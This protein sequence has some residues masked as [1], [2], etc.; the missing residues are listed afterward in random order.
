MLT[1]FTEEQRFT[2]WWLWL[3]LIL[4]SLIPIYAIYQQLIRGIPAGDKPISDVG[5]ILVAVFVFGLIALFRWMR[6]YTR[7]D[8]R[9]IFFH[10]RPF[11]QKRIS[12][13]E[14]RSAQ[15]VDYGFV[16]YGIRY[17]SRHG[18]V[19][20]T[21]GSKGLALVL[22]NGKKLVIGTQRP[23]ELRRFLQAHGLERTL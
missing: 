15:V 8:Q 5:V 17:G 6:L 4:I 20:N 18:V 21:N 11:V 13:G 14:V 23:E 1:T 3:L 2:Q 9:E 16:G 7:I 12:W 10:Y 22:T 19:Y